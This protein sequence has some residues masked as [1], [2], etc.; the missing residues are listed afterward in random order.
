MSEPGFEEFVTRFFHPGQVTTFVGAGGKSS[1]MRAVAEVLVRRGVRARLATTTRIGVEEFSG[2]PVAPVRGAL[3]LRRSFAAKEPLQVISAGL[4]EA[5]RKHA[6]LEAALIEQAELPADLVLMVEGDGARRMPLKAPLPHEPVIPSNSATVIALMGALAF[7]EPVDRA[8]CYNAE[9]VLA[10]LGR[11]E[12]ILD[13]AALSLLAGH[14]MGCRKGVLP[15]MAF[16]LV[17]NHGDLAEKRPISRALMEE[18]RRRYGI[19]STLLSW[20]ERTVYD[21]AW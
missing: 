11:E 4:L 19:S 13:A 15:G 20:R 8:R 9:G 17:I 3:D 1:G 5:G 12:A 10:L 6:G 16:A 7:G 2:L 18:A 21:A 14:P